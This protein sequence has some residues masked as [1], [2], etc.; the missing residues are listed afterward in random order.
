MPAPTNI[1]DVTV[2][3]KANVYFDGK[4]VSHTLVNKRG[5][6]QTVGVIYPGTY[7]FNT[8]APEQMDIT[9]GECVYKLAGE[10]EWQACKAGRFFKVA[11]KSAFDIR[12]ENGLCEYLCSFL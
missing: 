5:D 10:K 8:D 12:I 2:T 9:A 1:N 4:V 6:R 11:G 3:L 7:T